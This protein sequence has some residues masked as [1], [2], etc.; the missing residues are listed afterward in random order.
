[1]QKESFCTD[2]ECEKSASEKKIFTETEYFPIELP[3]DFPVYHFAYTQKTFSHRRLHYHNGFE[4]GVCLEGEGLFFVGSRIYEF[5]TGS[6]SFISQNQPHIA[7]SP[8]NHPSRWLYITID[9][10]KMFDNLS[11]DIKNNILNDYELAELVKIT[12]GELERMQISYKAA[13]KSLLYTIFLKV[14]RAEEISPEFS[15]SK[16]IHSVY[17]AIKF[18][19]QNY[20]REFTIEEIAK[21]NG[22]SVNHFRRVFSMETGFSPLEYIIRVRLKMAAVLL[23]STDKKISDISFDVGFATLSSF[24]RYFKSHYGISPT[25]FR[26][27]WTS[28]SFS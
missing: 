27:K 23:R 19:S 2:N 12:F 21:I 17:P 15:S 3:P 24:N 1:M 28:G 9:A 5:K 20:N 16:N 13:V 8:D 6:T 18:I 22:Y 14:M 10:E 7:Q 25:E 4:I 26:K 11:L